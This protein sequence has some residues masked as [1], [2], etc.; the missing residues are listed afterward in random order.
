LLASLAARAQHPQLDAAYDAVKQGDLTL[1]QQEID[2]AATNEA[3][4]NLAKTWYLKGFIY[5]EL[6]QQPD[7]N[8][9]YRDTALEALQKCTQYNNDNPLIKSCT[10]LA[11]YLYVTYF[12]QGI[13]L[14]NT[15]QYTE[16]IAHFSKFMAGQPY[17]AVGKPYLDALYYSGLA[18]EYTGNNAEAIRLYE[19]ALSYRYEEPNLYSQLAYLYEHANDLANS[20]RVIDEGM[21]RFAQDQNMQITAIN[22]L[23]G[24]NKYLAVEPILEAYLAQYPNDTEV[25]LVAGTVYQKISDMHPGKK[26]YAYQ[27]CKDIYTK[28]LAADPNNF[29]ANYNMGIV[30][31]N[32]AVDII[33]RQDYDTNLMDLESIMETCSSL[34]AEALPYVEKANNL[35]PNNENLLKALAGIYHNLGDMENLGLVEEALLARGQ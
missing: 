32:K 27:K 26:N 5:K 22:V 13:D 14:F 29:N 1:A 15:E 16:A 7:G 8:P 35:Q 25:L 3:T 2:A 21:E 17:E 19:R 6:Y 10:E 23:V 30:I 33:N 28:V 20:V 18:N 11:G 4:M 24:F 12:N 34:F 31:F 9:T